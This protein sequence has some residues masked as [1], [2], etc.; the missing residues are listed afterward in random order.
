M[1]TFLSQSR[2]AIYFKNP[3]Q[4]D[5]IIRHLLTTRTVTQELTY[6]LVRVGTKEAIIVHRHDVLVIINEGTASSNV[7]LQVYMCVC[8]N[9]YI[10]MHVY[11]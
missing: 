6:L 4:L 9:M 10:Y 8:V 11:I 3:S 5:C 7:L 1:Y 2:V